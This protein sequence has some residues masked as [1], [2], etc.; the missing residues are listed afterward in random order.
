MPRSYQRGKLIQ[1]L[2]VSPN[3]ALRRLAWTPRTAKPAAGVGKARR[4]T[5]LPRQPTDCPRCHLFSIITANRPV[6]LP[7]STARPRV[8]PLVRSFLEGLPPDR[9]D[10]QRTLCSADCGLWSGVACAAG[11]SAARICYARRIQQQNGKR[12]NACETAGHRVQCNSWRRRLYRAVSRKTGVVLLALSN[13]VVN[14]VGT[15]SASPQDK[16]QTALQH[17]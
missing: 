6:R 13:V 8:T 15:F 12:W 3:I 4:W 11:R 17:R 5:E 14:D 1:T 7:L 9:A 2:M 16:T 10:R